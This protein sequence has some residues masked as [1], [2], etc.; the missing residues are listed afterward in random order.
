[1]T[2]PVTNSAPVTDEW[3]DRL[4]DTGAADVNHD[5]RPAPAQ[6]LVSVP[7]GRLP[8]WWSGEDALK[9]G[10]PDPT[11][12]PDDAEE[13]QEH[14]VDGEQLH[15]ASDVDVEEVPAKRRRLPRPDWSSWGGDRE[16]VGIRLNP[17][18]RRVAY[19]AS[20]AA[21]GWSFGLVELCSD[22]IEAAGHEFSV[23]T[24]LALGAC[25]CGV[26]ALIDSRTRRWWPPLAWVARAPLASA[27]LALLLY[28]PGA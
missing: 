3:W 15:D 12:D 24:A 8:E 25:I 1:M 2:E 7:K 5:A 13:D 22:A 27:V 4:Y 6:R 19:N 21:L 20:A 23:H 28:A 18:A 10:E 17:R 14:D 26:I 9:A 16:Q 11:A